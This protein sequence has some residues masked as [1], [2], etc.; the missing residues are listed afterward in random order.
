MVEKDR[1]NIRRYSGHKPCY[2]IPVKS[3]ENQR[4]ENELRTWMTSFEALLKPVM[5]VVLAG[6]G[7]VGGAAVTSYIGVKNA[8]NEVNSV[9]ENRV[10][11]RIEKKCAKIDVE[12]V[13][14]YCLFMS[15]TLPAKN[16]REEQGQESRGKVRKFD[17]VCVLMLL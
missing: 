13:R 9:L 16:I 10:D 7:L 17:F 8:Q 11:K 15:L 3:R 4:A 1:Q 12:L 6:L 14:Y 5:A 2:H